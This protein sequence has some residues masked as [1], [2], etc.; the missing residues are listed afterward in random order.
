M[1]KTITFLAKDL[2]KKIRLDKYLADNLNDLTRSQIKKII[3]KIHKS[4]YKITFV[5]SGGGT[6]AISS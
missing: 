3:K 6:N 2:G 1:N 5:S 4:P